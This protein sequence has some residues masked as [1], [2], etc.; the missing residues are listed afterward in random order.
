METPEQ[1]NIWYTGSVDPWW[2]IEGFY[3]LDYENKPFN[4]SA[5]Q[6]QWNKRG[7]EKQKFTGD[8][9]GMP[10]DMP[11]WIEPFETIFDWKH[12]SWQLYKMGPGT[13]LPSHK[14]TYERF[15][16]LYN[17]EDPD[18]IYRAVVFLEDWQSGHY[19]EIDN[20]NLSYWKKGDYVVWQNS[21]SH[22][23]ANIGEVPR[24]T[25]QITGVVNES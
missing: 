8:L 15:K 23:A 3:F 11:T 2:T 12:F 21:V 16:E 19:F 7:F 13:V 10:N 17:V 5:T 24:Y 9:Y 4:D 22:L 18:T 6:A 14:D 20:T 1:I 25:L